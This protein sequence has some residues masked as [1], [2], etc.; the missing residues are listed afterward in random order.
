MK[1]AIVGLIAI[2]MSA[3]TTWND[4]DAPS[5]DKS[6]LPTKSQVREEW[7]RAACHLDAGAL[8]DPCMSEDQTCCQ[9]IKEDRK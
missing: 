9:V 3:C 8:L 4:A 1:Y 5:K 2:S 6:T 7:K